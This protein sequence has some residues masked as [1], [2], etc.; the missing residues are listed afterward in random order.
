[1]L[2]LSSPKETGVREDEG[3]IILILMLQFWY[4]KCKEKSRKKDRKFY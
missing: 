1:M 3:E 4:L 2:Q